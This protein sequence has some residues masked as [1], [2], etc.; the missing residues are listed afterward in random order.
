MRE[1]VPKY[2][3]ESLEQVYYPNLLRDSDNVVFSENVTY[4]V[5]ENMHGKV[6]Q[7]L[8]EIESMVKKYCVNVDLAYHD[9]SGNR[10]IFLVLEKNQTEP[11]LRRMQTLYSKLHKKLNLQMLGSQFWIATILVNFDWN[12]EAEAQAMGEV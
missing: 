10:W 7:E 2:P 11:I 5:S 8:K 12:V 6:V 1:Y 3:L 9:F 4:F